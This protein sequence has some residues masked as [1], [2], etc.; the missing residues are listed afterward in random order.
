MAHRSALWLLFLISLPLSSCAEAPSETPG[1]S[2]AGA[3]YKRLKLAVVEPT[4]SAERFNAGVVED[5]TKIFVAQ[6]GTVTV[7]K[8]PEEARAGSPDLITL[9][10]VDS[11]QS[12]HIFAGARIDVHARFIAPDSR[13]LEELHVYGSQH[14]RPFLLPH[15]VNEH[16]REKTRAQMQVALLSSAKLAAFAKAPR[17]VAKGGTR[18]GPAMILHSDIDTPTYKLRETPDNYALVIGIEQYADLPDAQFAARDADTVRAHLVAL[19]YPDRNVIYLTGQ[20]ATRAGIQKYLHE[21]LPRNVK[22]SST[23]FF[24]YSGHGAPDTKTGEAYLV[25]W[26]GDPQFLAT[27]AYP[28]KEVYAALEKLPARDVTVVLDSCFSG[29]GGRSVLAA[30]LRPMVITVESG[31]LP[32][33][34]LALFAAASRDEVTGGLDEQGHGIFTYYFLKGLSGAAKNASGTVTLKGLFEYVKPLVQDAAR[35]QNRDQ[36]PVLYG[37]QQDHPIIRFD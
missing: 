30:G 29:A 14:P 10:S 31:F 33:G 8:T 36:T 1:D 7:L 13:V 25:P 22:P 18:P 23:V 9:L 21:W 16:A 28:L 11:E 6:F 32:Q 34:R 3:L 20:S 2:N 15:E 17:S 24:Y 27:T 5:M 4:A 12:T 26:D 19:G 35:R 37:L